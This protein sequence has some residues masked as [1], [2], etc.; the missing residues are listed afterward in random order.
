MRLNALFQRGALTD[1][2]IRR[3]LLQENLERKLGEIE[4]RA[5]LFYRREYIQYFR[6]FFINNNSYEIPTTVIRE[7][8]YPC[9][10]LER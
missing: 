2:G 3:S 8:Y 6:R 10:P 9:E 4:N 7:T 1:V 5:D